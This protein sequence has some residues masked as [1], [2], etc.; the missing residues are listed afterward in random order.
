MS[1]TTRARLD[2][3]KIGLFVIAAAVL[4]TVALLRLDV[5]RTEPRQELK[6]R[7]S[8]TGG[9]ESGAVV[10]MA[11][12]PVGEVKDLKIVRSGEGKIAV[13]VTAGVEPGVVVPSDSEIVISTHGL[14]GTK[15]L[16]ILPGSLGPRPAGDVFTGRDPVQ[17]DAM[18]AAGERMARKMER[19]V[20]LVNQLVEDQDFKTSLK[21]NTENVSALIAELRQAARSMNEILDG[22]K[23]GKGLIGKLLTDEAVYAD[24]KETVADLKKNPWK[25]LKKR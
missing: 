1:T 9:L 18:I 4:L 8:F 25:L 6:A 20:D 15:Y 21:T 2:E 16:E 5:V 23:S 13:E 24:V 17:I 3:F 19:T 7:F 10:Q 14:L 12:V 22:A 11:G